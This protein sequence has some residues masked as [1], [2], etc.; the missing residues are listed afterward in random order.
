VPLAIARLVRRPQIE[1]PA[2]LVAERDG[3]V[4]GYASYGDFRSGDGY[5]LTVE[6]SVYIHRELRGSGIA[7]H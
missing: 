1:E 6:D 5:R 4:V 2:I 7:R 3:R